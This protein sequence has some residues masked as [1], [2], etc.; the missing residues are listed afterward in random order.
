MVVRG[1]RWVGVGTERV[2]EMRAFAVDVLGLRVG[3]QDS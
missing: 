2:A 3:G 1:I